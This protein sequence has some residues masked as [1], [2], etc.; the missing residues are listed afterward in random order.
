MTDSTC[1]SWC[2]L[3][4]LVGRGGDS[5]GLLGIGFVDRYAGEGGGRGVFGREGDEYKL[6][7]QRI[8]GC[9]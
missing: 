6:S 9:C 3:L 1:R 5:N 7:D 2:D 8:L 4:G